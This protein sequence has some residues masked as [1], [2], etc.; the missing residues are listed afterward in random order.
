MT[1][2]SNVITPRSLFLRLFFSRMKVTLTAQL[3]AQPILASWVDT[4]AHLENVGFESPMMRRNEVRGTCLRLLGLEP[5]ADESAAREAYFRKAR[6]LH[7]DRN[8][9]AS[10]AV[11]AE[12]T[13]QLL[14]VKDCHN[15]L[16]EPTNDAFSKVE[17]LD[18]M[19]PSIFFNTQKRDTKYEEMF[20]ASMAPQRRAWEAQIRGMMAARKAAKRARAEEKAPEQ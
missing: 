9:K 3:L 19:P 5:D 10:A 8:V 17:N 18:D 16:Q 2:T 13:K 20:R 12:N 6:S 1:S 15:W 4:K 14:A 11:K 7:P